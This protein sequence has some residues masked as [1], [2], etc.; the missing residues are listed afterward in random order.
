MDNERVEKTKKNFSSDSHFYS[1]MKKLNNLD[2]SKNSQTKKI[3]TNPNTDSSLTQSKLKN[4]QTSQILPSSNLN[5]NNL[6]LTQSK[7]VSS[8]LQQSFKVTN[9]QQNVMENKDDFWNNITPQIQTKQSNTFVN[10]NFETNRST[11]INS[12][13]NT[14]GNTNLNKN[15]N[16]NDMASLIR[17]KTQ[18]MIIFKDDDKKNSVDNPSPIFPLYTTHDTL[19]NDIQY[20]EELPTVRKNSDMAKIQNETVFLKG[21][22]AEKEKEKERIMQENSNLINVKYKLEGALLSQNE[23]VNDLKKMNLS[24]KLQNQSELKRISTKIISKKIIR[25]SCPNATPDDEHF[26]NWNSKQK[27]HTNCSKC[28][29]FKSCRWICKFC[30]D[31]FCISCVPDCIFEGKCY[32]DHHLK[33]EILGANRECDRCGNSYVNS[34][35]WTDSECALDICKE[36]FIDLDNTTSGN[37]IVE[38]NNEFKSLFLIEFNDLMVKKIEKKDE[39]KIMNNIESNSYMFLT[40]FL[41]MYIPFL[42]LFLGKLLKLIFPFQISFWTGSNIAQDEIKLLQIPKQTCFS[43]YKENFSRGNILFLLKLLGVL[44]CFTILMTPSFLVIV[45]QFW[46]LLEFESD[47]SSIII[48]ID[49]F[50]ILKYLIIWI[51]ILMIC[52]EASKTINAIYFVSTKYAIEDWL[53]FI[54]LVLSL[55]PLFL[56]FLICWYLCYFN[57]ITIIDDDS[58]IDVIQNFAGFFIL[59]E[60]GKIILQFLKSIH[61]HDFFSWISSSDL[62]NISMN[63][64]NSNFKIEKTLVQ[65]LTKDDFYM[66]E[67]YE[68]LK[69][70]SSLFQYFFKQ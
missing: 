23:L 28:N 10:T 30:E 19:S 15:V 16:T 7:L 58:L 37:Y 21:I 24:M 4:L 42:F 27:T 62:I 6:D 31:Q 57:M 35:Y 25:Q 46:C 51:F 69:N 66:E 40:I 38:S 70:K 64:G 50:F 20:K 13:L 12:N 67:I 22:I 2:K 3:D 11:N 54:T 32:L 56:F 8:S 60:F 9:L 52:Q 26:L 59:L 33:E 18:D 48:E 47:S 39:K 61:F 45:I 5:L 55:T 14:N 43:Y 44:I 41:M 49:S 1:Y 68:E 65:I 29:I 36:C 34:I 53:K 17:I 63:V